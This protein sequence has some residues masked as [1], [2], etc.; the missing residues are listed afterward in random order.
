MLSCARVS[1][2]Q[3]SSAIVFYY[4]IVFRGYIRTFPLRF[5]I[6]VLMD[7]LHEKSRRGRGLGV[8]QN[9]CSALAGA[10]LPNCSRRSEARPYPSPRASG[11]KEWDGGEGGRQLRYFC[12]PEAA[13]PSQA[14]SKRT[15]GMALERAKGRLTCSGTSLALLN[16]CVALWP[17]HPGATLGGAR[18]KHPE[19]AVVSAAGHAGPS[20]GSRLRCDFPGAIP[21]NYPYLWQENRLLMHQHSCFDTFDE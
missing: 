5:L 1:Y 18:Q 7:E 17:S 15:C 2:S 3:A 8:D 6:T 14:V 11:R 9:G 19:S 12:S 4:P 21:G 16:P 13:L 10:W 20:E